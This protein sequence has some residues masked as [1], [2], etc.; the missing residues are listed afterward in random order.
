MDNYQRWYRKC[1]ECR[2]KKRVFAESLADVDAKIEAIK[3]Q[4]SKARDARATMV[5]EQDEFNQ[6]L[7][8]AE[9]N[10]RRS[11]LAIQVLTQISQQHDEPEHQ[12]AGPPIAPDGRQGLTEAADSD[13]GG[14]L[15]SRPSPQLT[16][17]GLQVAADTPRH[18][19]VVQQHDKTE[20]APYE[21]TATE[22]EPVKGRQAEQ[23]PRS[24]TEASADAASKGGATAGELSDRI[25]DTTVNPSQDNGEAKDDAPERAE[26]AG[27]ANARPESSE[28]LL[29]AEA[30]ATA[31]AEGSTETQFRNEMVPIADQDLNT[32]IDLETQKKGRIWL[33]NPKERGDF[34]KAVRAIAGVL[35]C[36]CEGCWRD[37]HDD[38]TSISDHPD[39]KNEIKWRKDQ[40]ARFS[41]RYKPDPAEK[42]W[43]ARTRGILQAAT[44]H[45]PFWRAA[46]RY[47]NKLI[48]DKKCI[49]AEL[50]V[51]EAQRSGACGEVRNEAWWR[52]WFYSWSKGKPLHWQPK[53]EGKD[54]RKHAPG[55]TS[56]GYKKYRKR[57]RDDY[58]NDNNH[59]SH[60]QFPVTGSSSLSQEMPESG[61]G[62]TATTRGQNDRCNSSFSG[63]AAADNHVPPANDNRAELPNVTQSE[64]ERTGTVEIGSRQVVT[65]DVV[66]TL[67][68]NGIHVADLDNAP[69]VAEIMKQVDAEA[70]KEGKLECSTAFW[71]KDWSRR[72]GEHQSNWAHRTWMKAHETVGIQMCWCNGCVADR[73]DTKIGKRRVIG[74]SRSSSPTTTTASDFS[75][76]SERHSP[77][78]PRQRSSRLSSILSAKTAEPTSTT[79]ASDF[80]DTSERHSP[81]TTEQA[82]SNRARALVASAE[83]GGNRRGSQY[84]GGCNAESYEQTLRSREKSHRT[85]RFKRGTRTIVSASKHKASIWTAVDAWITANRGACA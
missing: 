48:A 77:A 66:A 28:P 81:A 59:G 20:D 70:A 68:K 34:W 85:A 56:Q 26:Q 65:S 83:K 2:A 45:A 78:V 62:K 71:P 75:D 36:P 50:N 19:Q 12:N 23:G 54:K 63:E 84:Q 52:R 6:V 4:L 38:F 39:R 27:P 76:T 60:A 18:T 51:P 17:A 79:S 37:H 64:G 8:N 72:T 69:V 43:V 44:T 13:S 74:A 40:H 21:G 55:S 58:V 11:L 53:P 30:T 47:F 41:Q 32:F 5:A 14:D 7:R 22:Q 1:V 25:E 35:C 49:E 10:M 33:S 73:L 3:M 67:Q 61:L 80:S 16:T 24:I 15:L 82:S 29:P 42:Q 31:D 9:D 46:L 57:S